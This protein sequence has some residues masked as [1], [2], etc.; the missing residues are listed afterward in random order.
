M[1]A[2]DEFKH[3]EFNPFVGFADERDV[4]AIRRMLHEEIAHNRLFRGEVRAFMG[5]SETRMLALFHRLGVHDPAPDA[6]K[7]DEAMAEEVLGTFVLAPEYQGWRARLGVWL[8]Q[9]PTNRAFLYGGVA[10][11]L[12]ATLAACAVAR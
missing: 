3:S 2:D 6:P 7:V 11:S 9:R 12:L 5:R 10:V 4:V 8:A 1:S